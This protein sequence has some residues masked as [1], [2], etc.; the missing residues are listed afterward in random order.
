MAK[1]IFSEQEKQNIIKQYT[2]DK[3]SAKNIGKQYNTSAP[4]ILKNLREWGVPINTK[5]LD[6]SNQVFGDLTAISPALPREDKYTRWICKCS[7][8]K[9]VEVRTDYLTSRHTTSCG[10]TKLKYFNKIDLTGQRF[11]KLIVLGDIEPDSK[12]CKCDCGNI[13]IVKTINLTN[14]NTQ[15]C[16][17]L[18][19]KG[20][21][22]LNTILTNL[23]IPFQTQYSFND[24][25][26]PDSNRLAHFDY[27][28]FDQNKN[29]YCLIEYD[30]EQHIVGWQHRPESLTKIQAYDAYKNYY[31]LIHN[32]P[33]IRIPYSDYDKLNEN[34]ILNILK[35]EEAQDEV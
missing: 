18:K 20:E 17:C 16:G 21:L 11:G 4:T 13:T 10:H 2:T 15:S 24:C 23:N 12:K 3:I 31:C 14:G 1:I 29:I 33:L 32:I 5:T 25:K 34:Y 30:G 7:C 6:L 28:I 35:M 27:C 22:K 26:Y 19:S 9:T 8:G